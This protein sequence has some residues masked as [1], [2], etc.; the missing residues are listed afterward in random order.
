MGSFN[1]ALLLGRL[2]AD[3]Q[4]KT[5]KSGTVLATFRMAT[6]HL[7]D[8]E[9]VTQWH[10]VVCFGKTAEATVRFCQ[11]GKEVLVEGHV[12]YREYEDK[13]GNRR[14]T[15]EIV[16]QS[17]TFTGSASERDERRSTSRNQPTDGE[18]DSATGDDDIPF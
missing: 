16:A 4:Q 5:T 6:D 3:P 2:G 10:S 13:E 12:E 18:Q 14:F 7:R 11:K 9:R 1:K 15:T 8:G 17:V